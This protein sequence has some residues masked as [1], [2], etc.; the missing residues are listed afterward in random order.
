MSLTQNEYLIV[1]LLKRDRF[2]EVDSLLGNLPIWL[3]RKFNQWE[4]MRV[5]PELMF[6]ESAKIHVGRE[7]IE[8]STCY[9]QI[10]GSR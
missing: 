9:N 1:D 7:R 2:R 6:L 10:H 8:V 5:F 4:R 3:Y